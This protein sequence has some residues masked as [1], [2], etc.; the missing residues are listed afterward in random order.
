MPDDGVAVE[1]G[2]PEYPLDD[3]VAATTPAQLRAGADPTRSASRD[4]VLERAATT[5]ELALALGKPKG[6]VDHHLKVLERNGLLK[7]VRTRRVRAIDE[8]FWG[9]T[10][11]TI[12]I[13]PP[14]DAASADGDTANSS[15]EVDFVAQAHDEMRRVELVADGDV[16]L[17]TTLRHARISDADA[18]EFVRRIN[19]LAIEFSRHRRGG[20]TV[21]GLLMSLYPSDQPV[22]PPR[23]GDTDAAEEQP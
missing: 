5:T 1:G 10:G 3:E 17:T 18:E 16:V 9:R 23:A 14:R 8:R 22:L 7:V 4:L 6:T 19:E 21:Y 12:N 2:A 11:R 15:I 20:S 13:G